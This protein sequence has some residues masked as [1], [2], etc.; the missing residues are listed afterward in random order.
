VSKKVLAAACATSLAV[1]PIVAPAR[2]KQTYVLN[3]FRL[4]GVQRVDENA[5][6]MLCLTTAALP[7]HWR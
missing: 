3:G 4:G 2:A 1:A 5:L 6:D 7:S